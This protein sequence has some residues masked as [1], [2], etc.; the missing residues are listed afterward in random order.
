MSQPG[1]KLARSHLDAARLRFLCLWERQRDNAIAHL[2]FDFVLINLARN[3]KTA[4]EWKSQSA[5]GSVQ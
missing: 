4:S 5:T 1:C 3:P 2:G